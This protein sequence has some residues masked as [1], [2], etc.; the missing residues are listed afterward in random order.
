MLS[1]G[2]DQSKIQI[3]TAFQGPCII[4]GTSGA[5]TTTSRCPWHALR[6]AI[7]GHVLGE[8]GSIPNCQSAK[9]LQCHSGLTW[10]EGPS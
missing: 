1:E 4:F 2:H 3:G 6:M 9:P 5:S 8:R 10:A 7:G